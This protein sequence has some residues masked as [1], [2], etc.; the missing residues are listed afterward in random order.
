MD[1]WYDYKLTVATK[2]DTTHSQI[3]TAIN[4]DDAIDR[5]SIK[6]LK[7][8]YKYGEIVAYQIELIKTKEIITSQ[9]YLTIMD[10]V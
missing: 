7:M 1:K 9:V 3:Y 2:N 10:L 5:A 8:E 4:N 6:R